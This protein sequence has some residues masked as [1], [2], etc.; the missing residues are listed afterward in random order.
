MKKQKKFMELNQ[1]PPQLLI[2]NNDLKL[3]EN[4]SIPDKKEPLDIEVNENDHSVYIITEKNF[5]KQYNDTNMM[6]VELNN[7][8]RT[9]EVNE[10]S[11]IVY[12]I[13]DRDVSIINGTT[14]AKIDNIIPLLGPLLELEVNENSNIVYT[15]S[16]HGLY[17]LNEK[18]KRLSNI[19]VSEPLSNIEVNENS[20]IIYLTSEKSDSLFAIH[21]PKHKVAVEDYI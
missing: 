9:L 1:Y 2:F 19:D 12:V 13:S 11:N 7:K 3:L 8:P 5:Y 4:L 16:E 18:T 17:S 21:G 15:L 20:N 14:N 6:G 10:N